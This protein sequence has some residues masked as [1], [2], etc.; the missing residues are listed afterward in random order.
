MIALFFSVYSAFSMEQQSNSTFFDRVKQRA[1]LAG[2]LAAKCALVAK[3]TALAGVGWA[4]KKRA[5]LVAAIGAEYLFPTET[6]MQKRTWKGLIWD[7]IGTGYG[8][9]I[10]GINRATYVKYRDSSGAKQRCYEEKD[11]DRFEQLTD[12]QE[13]SYNLDPRLVQQER[14]VRIDNKLYWRT[15]A[16]EVCLD[17]LFFVGAKI[18]FNK[19]K[20]TH[21]SIPPFY[22]RVVSRIGNI[23]LHD[24]VIYALIRP[25][26]KF[27]LRVKKQGFYNALQSFWH[28]NQARVVEPTAI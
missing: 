26:I 10:C 12:E 21:A 15:I 18:L 1:H 3:N 23:V 16:E 5:N 19:A 17:L 27:G 8:Y 13:D 2:S 6:S 7:G 22:K 28:K 25:C 24:V 14:P 11:P 20:I 9:N 4:W